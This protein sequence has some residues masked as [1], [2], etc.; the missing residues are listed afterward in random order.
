M[1]IKT[2]NQ[3]IDTG[4]LSDIVNDFKFKINNSE[5]HKLSVCDQ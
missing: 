2:K 5:C 1:R 4:L 3:S